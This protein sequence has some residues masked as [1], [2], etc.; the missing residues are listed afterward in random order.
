MV[1]VRGKKYLQFFL[2]STSDIFIEIPEKDF[3]A[4]HKI[5]TLQNIFFPK[6]NASKIWL[7]LFFFIL[8]DKLAHL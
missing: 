8:A 3:S 4:L 2:Q 6:A 7:Y 5:K 1:K